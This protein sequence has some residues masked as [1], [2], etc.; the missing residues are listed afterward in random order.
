MEIIDKCK[1]MKFIM[2]AL[3]IEFLMHFLSV[4]RSLLALIILIF[5][6][7]MNNF[8]NKIYEY[9]N[10]INN[11][12]R[13]RQEKWEI[14][15]LIFSSHCFFFSL[16]IYYYYY[17]YYEDLV[18]QSREDVKEEEMIIPLMRFSSII[19]PCLVLCVC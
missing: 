15:L 11:N 8:I 7:T 4:L 3:T 19:M 6:S 10:S 17:Y 1:S 16:W 9:V 14:H 5:S 18:I 12:A 2:N 13:A